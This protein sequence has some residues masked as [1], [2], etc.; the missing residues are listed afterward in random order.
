MT[1][2]TLRG[3]APMVFA[4]LASNLSATGL[5]AATFTRASTGTYID[6]ADGLLKTAAADT[7]RF[8]KDGLLMEPQSTNLNE[9]SEDMIRWTAAGGSISAN[10]TTAPDGTA[11][12]DGLVEDGNAST[13]GF[14][15]SFPVTQGQKYAISFF[16]KGWGRTWCVIREDYYTGSNAYFDLGNGVCGSC[17]DYM[18]NPKIEKVANDCYRVSA[19]FTADATANR[20]FFIGGAGG[21]NGLQY[22]GNNGIVGIYVWG[23][24]VEALGTPTSYIPTNGSQV[25]RSADEV[26]WPLSDSL[27]SILSIDRAWSMSYQTKVGPFSGPAY[28]LC[29]FADG[30]AWA[31]FHEQ[32]ISPYASSG[33]MIILRDSSGNIAWGYLGAAGTGRT[34]GPDLL[35]NS[36]FESTANLI[37]INASIASVSGGQSGNCLAITRTGSTLS[38]SSYACQTITTASKKLYMIYVYIKTSTA[39]EP[40]SVWLSQ[41]GVGA[42]S[43]ACYTGASTGS[44]A[45]CA[46]YFVAGSSSTDVVLE[47]MGS[48][49][50]TML[51]DTAAVH[52]HLT[53]SAMGLYVYKDPSLSSQGWN[54]Q[55][56]FIMNSAAFTFDIVN[57]CKAEGTMIINLD[58]KGP[59]WNAA[60]PGLVSVGPGAHSTILYG[61]VSQG[62]GLALYDS[63][64]CIGQSTTLESV[65][66]AAV[67]FSTLKRQFALSI[68]SGG[69][70]THSAPAAFDGDFEI[71]SALALH[72]NN[73][74]PI[75]YKNL[76][77]HRRYL[78][79]SE[80]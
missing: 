5:A 42:I 31:E 15:K 64:S 46:F 47:N 35:S 13:H 37:A 53:P 54:M 3:R 56:G 51:F 69:T 40:Y 74:N 23:A 29:S 41:T 79:D 39:D 63:S 26:S 50:G 67:R 1:A 65:V 9:Y 10:S 21:D 48:L 22:T 49:A 18:S 36:V 8:E 38:A 27:K 20:V 7:P 24:Q 16:V 25:T 12:M 11:T 77:F 60:Y 28:N 43:G 2:M 80:L 75:H 70:W 52:E 73:S 55:S 68:S 62:T 19:V 44:W 33:K 45:K 71:A 61:D 17:A 30:Q 58:I 57:A 34:L 6:P 4:P 66:K 76:E 14:Y 59:T 32:D 72:R 78:S